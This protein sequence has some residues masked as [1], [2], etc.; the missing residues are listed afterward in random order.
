MPPKRVIVTKTALSQ[1]SHAD[2]NAFIGL[3]AMTDH[4]DLTTLQ[5]SAHLVFWYESEVQ[6]GGHL[7]FFL[8][9]SDDRMEETVSSLNTLGAPAQAQVLEQ[10]LA[11]WR[12][13]ARLPPAD[14]M[15]Y[16]AITFEMEFDDLDRA[17]HDCSIPLIEILRRHF[18]AHEAEYIIRE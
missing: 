10:A 5:R 13:A 3:L 4:D 6:N 12:G 11:R 8:N 1:N 7:Q 16:S 2:W 18:V 9:Q 17:F 15:E 14:A